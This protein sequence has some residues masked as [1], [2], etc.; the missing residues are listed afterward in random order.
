MAPFR[1]RQTLA[2]VAV[3][4]ALGSARAAGSRQPALGSA[5]VRAGSVVSA[6][7]TRPQR[8]GRQLKAAPAVSA[9]AAQPQRPGLKA[10]P[11]RGGGS[12]AASF[13]L[14]QP[15]PELPELPEG[16]L[17]V[18]MGNARFDDLSK[19]LSVCI[20]L[21]L[22]A[23][24]FFSVDADLSRGWTAFEIVQR[25]LPD[26]W[27]EYESAIAEDPVVTKTIINMVIYVLAD[28]L[29]QVL[30]GCKPFEFDE[31]RLFRSGL[32]GLFFGPVTCAYYEFSD[33][34][35]D[36]YIIANRPLKILMDQTLYAASKY[37]VFVFLREVIG[38]T[39]PE[40]AFGQARKSTW[41]LLKRGWRFWPA[42]HM[43]TYSVIPPRHRVLWVNC[44]DLVW[45]TILSLTVSSV[46]KEA[47][48][49][50]EGNE[51]PSST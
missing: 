21:G 36:P 24:R 29:S 51:K 8:P 20:V 17:G 3:V 14:S 12:G 42:V 23:Y 16:L 31:R 48:L 15:L 27:N 35:L 4:V 9:T 2:V 6:M 40:E 11:A 50:A 44:A 22:A 39:G 30:E 37:T 34:I 33:S 43:I 41:P 49:Q 10:A 45:V 25:L 5:R 19:V 46:A 28:W 13:P 7:A 1:L 38:G 32:I 18:E 47:A 26:N